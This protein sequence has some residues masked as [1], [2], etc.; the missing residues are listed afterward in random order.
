M[1]QE[2]EAQRDA[3][4]DSY[5]RAWA[6]GDALF[7]VSQRGRLETMNPVFLAELGDVYAR[8]QRYD[9]MLRY[10]Y[11]D[12]GLPARYDIAKPIADLARI[13]ESV[14]LVRRVEAPLEQVEEVLPETVSQIL[15]E[16]AVPSWSPSLSGQTASARS[17]TRSAAWILLVAGSGLLLLAVA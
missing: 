12:Q 10:M 3:A 2:Q 7:P 9:L 15:F 6:I 16:T 17:A 1:A 4:R 14:R 11:S 8:L 13:A 5:S